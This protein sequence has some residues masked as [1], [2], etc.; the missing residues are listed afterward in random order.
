GTGAGEK[1]GQG[2]IGVT[3]AP[4]APIVGVVD[5][6]SPAA[7][8]GLR[9]GDRIMSVDGRAV[10]SFGELDRALGTRPRRVLLAYLR[11]RAASAGFAEIRVYEPGI[12]DLVPETAARR[13]AWSG[14][15]SSGVFVAAG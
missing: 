1:R 14:T 12:A 13:P 2:L 11:G 7:R 10:A 15:A 8:A 4:F 9:T 6:T 3:E 5:P